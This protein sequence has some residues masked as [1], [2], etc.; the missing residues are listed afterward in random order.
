MPRGGC[1]NHA[2]ALHRVSAAKIPWIPLTCPHQ[3]G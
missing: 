1:G 3:D 2:G